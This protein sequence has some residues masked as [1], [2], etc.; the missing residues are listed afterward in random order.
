VVSTDDFAG[1]D[2]CAHGTEWVFSPTGSVKL[3]VRIGAL[4]RDIHIYAG[5]DDVCPDPVQS[6]EWDRRLTREF[7]VDKPVHISGSI[8]IAVGD[9]CVP[10]PTSEGQTALANDFLN[11][12][13]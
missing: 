3:S 13:Q 7:S 4:R 6:K 5:G 8:E 2:I 11:Q 12:S 10:H 9:N 1:H